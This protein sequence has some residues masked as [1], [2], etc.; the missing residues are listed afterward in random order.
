MLATI[1]SSTSRNAGNA[2]EQVIRRENELE[3]RRARHQRPARWP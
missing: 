1:T 2:Q 3:E